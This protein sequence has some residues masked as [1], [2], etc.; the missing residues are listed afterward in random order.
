[1]LKTNIVNTDSFM[2]FEIVD[3]DMVRIDSVSITKYYPYNVL[4][5]YHS[6]D[7]YVEEYSHAMSEL[8]DRYDGKIDFDTAIDARSQAEFELYKTVMG[9]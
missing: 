5:F 4:N 2:L 1:M 3:E 8:I 9:L 7:D 6:V